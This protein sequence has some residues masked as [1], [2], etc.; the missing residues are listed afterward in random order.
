M[1]VNN[2]C[3]LGRGINRAGEGTGGFIRLVPGMGVPGVASARC[4][5]PCSV[6]SRARSCGPAAAMPMAMAMAA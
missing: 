3:F 6:C 5:A 4:P 1:P 2:V